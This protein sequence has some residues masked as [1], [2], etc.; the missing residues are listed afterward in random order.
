MVSCGSTEILLEKHIT[1]NKTCESIKRFKILYSGKDVYY[2]SNLV[3]FGLKNYTY[4]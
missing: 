2:P 1:C 4:L 3:Y